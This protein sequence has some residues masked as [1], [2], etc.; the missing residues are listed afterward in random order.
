[1]QIL[2]HMHICN[3]S[4]I[5]LGT[6][7]NFVTIA[8]YYK[9]MRPSLV[10]SHF[11]NK[12]TENKRSDMNNVTELVTSRA[13]TWAQFSLGTIAAVNHHTVRQTFIHS[14]N[15]YGR[16]SIC[17]TSY[18]MLKLQIP[19]GCRVFFLHWYHSLT[20]KINILTRNTL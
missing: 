14:I 16:P 5:R 18:Q 15:I 9:P 6:M 4:V 2:I 3:C 20:R 19:I 17:E 10:L 12:H 13:K 11:T 7:T 1:M 8:S